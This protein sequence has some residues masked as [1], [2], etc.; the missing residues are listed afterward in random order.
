MEYSIENEELTLLITK[1]LTANYVSDYKLSLEKLSQM[2][3]QYRVCILNLNQTMN[4]DSSGVTFVI[5]LY[6]KMKSLEKEFTVIVAGE[7]I[8]DLFRLMKLDQFFELKE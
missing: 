5:N 6:K 2:H 1:G 4:I 3:T 7:E 8:Q